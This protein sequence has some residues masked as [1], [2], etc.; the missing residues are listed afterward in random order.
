MESRKSRPQEDAPLHLAKFTLWYAFSA[1][2]IVG[3]VFLKENVDCETCGAP[4]E[5]NCIHFCKE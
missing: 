4:L 3:P 2:G 5:E 1:V